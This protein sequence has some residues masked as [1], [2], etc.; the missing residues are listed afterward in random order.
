MGTVVFPDADVKFFLDAS[1]KTRALR[2]YRELESTIS[3]T[4]A[5]VEKDMKQRDEN[6]STRELA[7]LK[8]AEDAIII[9]STGIS[10]SEVVDLMLQYIKPKL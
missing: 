9:D 10:A 3:Q 6:D 2:R 8:P 5:E 1:N 7:P 4:L